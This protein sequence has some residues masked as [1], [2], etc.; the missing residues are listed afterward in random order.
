MRLTR[1][2]SMIPVILAASAASAA[3]QVCV[4]V[5]ETRDTFSTSD[6]TA[7]ILLVSK[8]FELEGEHVA[9]AGCSNLYTLSHISLGNTIIVTLSGPLGRREG[10]ALGMDD[11]PALY[12]QMVRSLIT[13]R[14][15]TG[16]NVTDRTNVTAAQSS[17][18]RI[19]GDSLWYA[20]LGY[21]GVFAG[22]TYGAPLFGFGYRYELDKW[23]LDVSFLNFQVNSS[24]EPYYYGTRPESK[25]V[26]AG[27]ILKL[28][29]LYFMNGKANNT[30]Y[31]GA[32]LS[33]GGTT[34]GYDTHGDGL[35][36]E[37][38]AGYEF[39]RSSALRM[40]VQTDAVLPFYN[41]TSVQYPN[42]PIP[43]PRNYVAPPPTVVHR[44]A[45]SLSVSLGFGWGKGRRGR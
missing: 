24:S 3:A 32:G 23:G 2:C 37:L 39:P 8:Q 1:F 43:I 27:S 12:N 38:S 4:T 28:Q 42:P 21:S 17:T 16:F 7:A 19:H 10:R 34:V 36:A 41:L 5:D 13:G 25:S 14:P 30:P 11:L 35:A 22:Q 9:D 6:R 20:R 45:P 40:F 31:V 33:Y 44:Y 15:M 26:F 18:E 29:G